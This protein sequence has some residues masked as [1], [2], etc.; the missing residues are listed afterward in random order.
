M[1][2]HYLVAWTSLWSMKRNFQNSSRFGIRNKNLATIVATVLL[3]SQS[4]FATTLVVLVSGNAIVFGADGKGVHTRV[5]NSNVVPVATNAFEK[6][7]ILQNRIL[8]ST[9]GIGRIS[10]AYDFNTWITSLPIA[11]NASIE[12]VAAIIRKMCKPIFE[13]E[14]NY[15]LRRGNTP[16][17]NLSGDKSLPVVS[18]YVAGNEFTGPR[19]YLVEIYVNWSKN[20]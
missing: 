11:E 13:R 5:Q 20:Q 15:E 9:A 19:V 16:I 14:W 7:A 17:T 6:I 12:D 2:G 1:D 18:Y 8:V 10:G 4:G 3:C